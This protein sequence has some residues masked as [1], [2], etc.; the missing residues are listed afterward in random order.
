M[1]AITLVAVESTKELT[2]P[3]NFLNAIVCITCIF[4]NL[5][6]ESPIAELFSPYVI[7]S[8]L[9]IEDIVQL[10]CGVLYR[11]AATLITVL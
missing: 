11:H 6:S 2:S 5:I 9:F 1:C 8:K 4:N 10:E 7:L 3:K